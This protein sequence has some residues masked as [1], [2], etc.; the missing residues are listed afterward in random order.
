MR[1]VIT[2]NITINVENKKRRTQ[3]EGIHTFA[4]GETH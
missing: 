2:K 1:R 3:Q 4:L